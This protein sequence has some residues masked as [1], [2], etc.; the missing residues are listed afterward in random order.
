MAVST[1]RLF[2][3]IVGFFAA[4]QGGPA[5]A[6]TEPPRPH[7]RPQ[8]M[9]HGET[10]GMPAFIARLRQDAALRARFVRDPRTVLREHGVDPSPFQVTD[11]LDETK[12]EALLMAWSAATRGRFN[13]A[14]A[15]PQAPAAPALS[16][17]VYGSPP[18]P[19]IQPAPPG[20]GSRG[21]PHADQT[22][23]EADQPTPPAPV[24]GPPPGPPSNGPDR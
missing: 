2:Q 20:Q 18:R 14:Q 19:P 21:H 11:R 23:P 8:V 6:A 17:V 13:L 24:Y 12:L 22:K 5:T 3:L 4:L 16:P 10:L 1:H 9:P 15:T 7:V